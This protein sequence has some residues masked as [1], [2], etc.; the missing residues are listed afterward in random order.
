MSPGKL[1]QILFAP[2]GANSCEAFPS[3]LTP[4]RERR[5]RIKDYGIN[6]LLALLVDQFLKFWTVSNVALNTGI[7]PLIPGFLHITYIKNFGAVFGV[8]SGFGALRWILLILLI[9][10]TALM[11]FAFLKGYFRT[12][13]IKLSGALLLAGLLGNGIDR[14][15][16]G[17]VP[18]I[19]E[20]EFVKFAIFN[21]ADVLVLVGGILFVAA[22]LT[23]GLRRADEYD[24]YE[25]APA[26]A[27]RRRAYDEEPAPR[28][29]PRT[30]AEEVPVRRTAPRASAPAA[31]APSA[32]GT[33]A[34][35]P[36]RQRAAGNG[37]PVAQPR[38]KRVID[39]NSVPVPVRPAARPAAA[40]QR[41]AETQRTA[42]PQRAAEPVRRTAAP[43]APVTRADLAAQNE[44]TVR[45]VARPAAS[46]R[47]AAPKAAPAPAP[48]RET[49]KTAPAPAKEAPK[50]APPEE[51][52][53]DSIL[54]EF[55]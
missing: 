11:V 23:G 45:T 3:V 15:I 42:A 54:A 47:P 44:A 55:K 8:M 28:R 36:A 19:F 53:L 5:I 4:H 21:L 14:A 46:A 7:R 13:F 2:A 50:A 52:D 31:A 51:F 20:F 16:Y 10:F 26:R 41:A 49:P 29:A 37:V 48:V 35:S 38:A 18:D 25:E 17:Y 22:I 9:A 32:R 1:I 6:A 27:S 30:A 33:A 24:D 39:E 43:A 12:G 40:V 34:P